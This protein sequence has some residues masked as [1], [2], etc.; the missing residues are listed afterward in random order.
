M[1]EG[2]LR[3]MHTYTRHKNNACMHAQAKTGV[4]SI[5]LRTAAL[6]GEICPVMA[7]NEGC[8]G[9]VT[10]HLAK[11][12]ELWGAMRGLQGMDCLCVYR[13]NELG[14]WLEHGQ[15]LRFCHRQCWCSAAGRKEGMRRGGSKLSAEKKREKRR[16]RQWSRQKN[17][18]VRDKEG[19]RMY[20]QPCRKTQLIVVRVMRQYWCYTRRI[21]TLIGD[22]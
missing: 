17:R 19:M 16:Q 10:L 12:W 11:T 2:T 18:G 3:R 1:N 13:Y 7:V 14:R 21:F 15:T 6:E 4:P 22:S 9:T 8:G 20:E 5:R